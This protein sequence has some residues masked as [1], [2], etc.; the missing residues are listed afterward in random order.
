MGFDI[1]NDTL[2]PTLNRF[3]ENVA[4]G[5][6]LAFKWGE[7]RAEQYAKVNAPW[8][9]QTGNARNGLTARYTRSGKTHRLT[10]FHRVNYG[11]W[12]EV[13]FSGRYA[14]IMPT[15]KAIRGELL[16]VVAASVRRATTGR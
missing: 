4:R 1:K 9:D 15:L 7:N 8:E 6:A 14:I 16:Q 10:L 3:D 13:R 11:I 5:V 12:L 2:R